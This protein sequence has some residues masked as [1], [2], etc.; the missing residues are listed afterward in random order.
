MIP[1]LKI[2]PSSPYQRFFWRLG[3]L[4]QFRKRQIKNWA[5]PGDMYYTA[6]AEWILFESAPC[7]PQ[8]KVQYSFNFFCLSWL[9]APPAL[10]FFWV[11]CDGVK[12]IKYLYGV[13]IDFYTGERPSGSNGKAFAQFS[14]YG[15]YLFLVCRLN[16]STRRGIEESTVHGIYEGE[17]FL[18]PS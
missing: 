5:L 2:A 3:T 8:E 17:M 6:L 9:K 14:Q 12:S 15:T 13:T 11:H 4:V 1:K 10:S 7:V 18:N 16:D